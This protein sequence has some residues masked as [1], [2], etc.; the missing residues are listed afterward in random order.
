MDQVNH[1]HDA[2]ELHA[3]ASSMIDPSFHITM[4]DFEQYYN[5]LSIDLP[6]DVH[7]VCSPCELFKAMQYLEV[8][9]QRGFKIKF[10]I[11]RNEYGA[12]CFLASIGKYVMDPRWSVVKTFDRFVSMG[13]TFLYLS[14]EGSMKSWEEIV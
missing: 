6:G 4:A 14:E 7:S 12:I 8:A 11:A 9:Q 3:E 2:F 1:W 5:I 13:Y 10:A